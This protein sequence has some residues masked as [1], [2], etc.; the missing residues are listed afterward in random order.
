[1][2]PDPAHERARSRFA[3]IQLLRWTGVVLAL[4]GLFILSGRTGLPQ[5]AG[6]ALAA[7]G[8]IDALLI[9]PL[10]SRHWKSPPQ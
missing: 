4:F 7:V 8:L 2:T 10:L 1:M 6:Y 5:I 9:P 3:V